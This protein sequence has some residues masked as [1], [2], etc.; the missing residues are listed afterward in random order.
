MG[1]RKYMNGHGT[2]THTHSNTYTQKIT[3]FTGKMKVKNENRCTNVCWLHYNS[4]TNVLQEIFNLCILFFLVDSYFLFISQNS[5]SRT[6]KLN[7]T[8]F[9]WT[10]TCSSPFETRCVNA[11]AF[12]DQTKLLRLL[13][14]TLNYIVWIS[15]PVP[16]NL[17][18]ELQYELYI[19]IY[20]YWGP[21]WHSG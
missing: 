7:N 11:S 2:N 1:L 8:L 10:A 12:S 20:I 19:Y 5:T 13:V 9:S 17:L 16:S 18:V 21:R 4:V 15:S 6:T 3:R 14:P